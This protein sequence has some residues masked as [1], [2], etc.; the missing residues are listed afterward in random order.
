MTQIDWS[1]EESQEFIDYGRYFVPERELQMSTVC[2]L[3]PA[4]KESFVVLELCC[5]EGLLAKAILT[6]YPQAT[7]YGY[8]GSP[9]MLK[10]A[11]ARLAPF[12]ER[13]QIR[14]FDLFSDSWRSLDFQPQAIVSSL[15]VHHLDG[16]QKQQLFHDMYV[17]LQPGGALIL[18]DLI[19]PM[20]PQALRY[21]AVQWDAAVRQRALDI[22]GRLDAFEFFEREK[23]NYYTYPDPM[24]KPSGILEQLQ[25][26]STV[27]FTAVD[28]YYLKAGHAIFG[29]MK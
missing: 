6:R 25:W 8:D 3:I 10:A 21:A 11:T 28:V 4:V 23:W 7:V 16:P 22:D 20:H 5:G 19:M 15:A 1:E 26:L 18:A 14:Q 17:L 2:D 9:E 29:G 12:G 27:G 13:F 24:D